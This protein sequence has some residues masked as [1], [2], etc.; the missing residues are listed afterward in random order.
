MARRRNRPLSGMLA[1]AAMLCIFTGLF[2]IPCGVCG[3]LVAAPRLAGARPS[4]AAYLDVNAPAWRAVE[5]IKPITLLMLAPLSLTA[6]FGVYFRQRW[7]RILAILVAFGLLVVM[8]LHLTYLLGAYLPAMRAYESQQPFPSRDY[9]VE[10]VMV[11]ISDIFWMALS[12][13]IILS[14]LNRPASRALSPYAVAPRDFEEVED[15][16]RENQE[17]LR[18]RPTI[19]EVY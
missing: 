16:E 1:L 2:Q 12:I 13:G 17:R 7:A 11:I 9:E 3:G 10:F 18:R 8:A 14:L 5:T 4:Q 19:D 15:E 6:G